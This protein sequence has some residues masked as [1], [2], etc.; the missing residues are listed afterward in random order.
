MFLTADAFGVLPPISRLT[1]EQAAYHFISGYTAKL[2]GTEVGVKEPKAT[3]S[4]CFG[5]PFMPRHPGRVRRMLVERL[6]RDDVPVWLVNTGWT[7]GPYGTG[8]RMNIAHTRSMV[9]AALDGSLG[10]RA[11]PARSELRRRGPAV[12]P[13]RAG[14]VPRPARDVGRSRGLRPRGRQAERD[15]PRQLRGLRRTAWTPRSPRPAP[16][17]TPAE[18]RLPRLIRGL[19]RRRPSRRAGRR[20]PGGRDD[21]PRSGR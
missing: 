18:R 13:G 12:V 8:E 4:A 3:F 11:D 16:V 2:A 21:R 15:V 14:V 20:G 7:G 19:V 17:R 9:R 10:A 1:R 6:E 5:A